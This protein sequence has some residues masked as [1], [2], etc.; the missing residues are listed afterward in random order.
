MAFRGAAGIGKTATLREL[1]RGSNNRDGTRWP[2]R[3]CL[4]VALATATALEQVTFP[5]SQLHVQ[6]GRKHLIPIA[7]V[8]CLRQCVRKTP[9]SAGC[10]CP[11]DLDAGL[12]R[13]L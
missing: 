5:W 7:V 9:L 6:S 3:P 4:G 11:G 13:P 8:G 2:Q 12:H 1:Q 10:V